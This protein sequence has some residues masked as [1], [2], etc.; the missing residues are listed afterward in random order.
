MS[1]STS[2]TVTDVSCG[3]DDISTLDS[4]VSSCAAT[5]SQQF[6]ASGELCAALGLGIIECLAQ[7]SCEESY[8]NKE[9]NCGL[10][11][12]RSACSRSDTIIAPPPKT[13]ASDGDPGQSTV[14]GSTA[15]GAQ[16]GGASASGGVL[17]D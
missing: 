7:S 2:T 1:G 14:G 9:D 12:A 10:R 13:R 3:C 6:M 17:N 15:T 11:A 16:S 4:C 5:F 8:Q